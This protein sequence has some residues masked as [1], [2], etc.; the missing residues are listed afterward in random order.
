MPE[1]LHTLVATTS[2]VAA[3][4]QAF[5]GIKRD[6][7]VQSQTDWLWRGVAEDGNVLDMKNATSSQEQ[8]SC[9]KV[10]QKTALGKTLDPSDNGDG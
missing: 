2:A 4:R 10:E 8:K 3:P 5:P 1:A 7:L 6:A 9:S